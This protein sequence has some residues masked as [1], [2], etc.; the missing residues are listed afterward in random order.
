MHLTSSPPNL[1]FCFMLFPSVATGSYST[2]MQLQPQLSTHEN[3][4]ED[5]E[6]RKCSSSVQKMVYYMPVT[7]HT[8]PRALSHLWITFDTS[9][10]ASSC[11]T[12]LFRERGCTCLGQRQLSPIFLIRSWLN[13]K[14]WNP[15]IRRPQCLCVC[16]RR[17]HM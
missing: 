1:V 6:I 2:G 3:W 14:M 16:V 8:L 9:Y 10:N 15:N 4:S 13:L 7:I 12:A 5:S 11:Y 17:R